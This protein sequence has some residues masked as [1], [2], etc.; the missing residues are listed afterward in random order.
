MDELDREFS[1][2]GAAGGGEEGGGDLPLLTRE[3]RETI[4]ARSAQRATADGSRQPITGA[5]EGA[6]KRADPPP[7]GG[8][9]GARVARKSASGSGEQI[10]PF[11][12]PSEPPG[13]P[14]AGAVATGI[15]VDAQQA[16][17]LVER[18]SER[19]AARVECT[20]GARIEGF[21]EALQEISPPGR[22]SVDAETVPSS[23]LVPAGSHWSRAWL[24]VG[25]SIAFGIGGWAW[26]GG[27][28]RATM[29]AERATW[30]A[31]LPNVRASLAT[32]WGERWLR[33][34][35]ANPRR[36]IEDIEACM[37]AAG[38]RIQRSTAGGEA[39]AGSGATQ[40]WRLAR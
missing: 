18:L 13:P 29:A 38:L 17:G 5:G 6:G 7:K 27:A 1:D 22:A 23:A 15:T 4:T 36:A 3:D 24:V 12:Q 28:D 33:M 31:Q 9:P 26:R 19:L 10:A 40:G 39:C 32:P 21:L 37:P 16:E 35:A 8:R 30:V 25:A 2:L 20:V 14:S 11:G 34:L